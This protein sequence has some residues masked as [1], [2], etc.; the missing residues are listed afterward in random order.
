MEECGN[1]EKKV[2]VSAEE[3]FIILLSADMFTSPLN[4][5]LTLG[6]SPPIWPKSFV[7]AELHNFTEYKAGV[8][9]GGLPIISER[10]ELHW[11]TIHHF[12][13]I[14]KRIYPGFRNNFAIL[15]SIL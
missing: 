10:K 14:L 3:C 4:L 12:K 6:S 2:A 9:E 1:L 5:T 13:Q 7:L 15:R 8:A 11:Q